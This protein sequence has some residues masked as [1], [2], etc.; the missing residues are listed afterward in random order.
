MGE[1]TPAESIKHIAEC[2][3]KAHG[4]TEYC[5]IVIEN[6]AGQGNVIGSKLQEL[7]DIISLVEN[8]KRIGVCL[9]TCHLFAAGYDIR[10]SE[11]W[12]SVMADFESTVGIEY[13]KAMHLNDSMGDLACGKDRHENLGKGKIGMEAFR[14]IMND[15]RLNGIPMILETP[16]PANDKAKEDEIY[17]NEISTL[18]SFEK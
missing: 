14:A 17:A 11:K 8:K 6:M 5:T 10:T 12:N 1:C 15:P 2:I 7:A 3:N 4:E 16:V 13:L 9:D 18:Y